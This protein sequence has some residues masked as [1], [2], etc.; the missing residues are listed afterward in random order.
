[1]NSNRNSILPEI[2]YKQPF[3]RK[4][5]CNKSMG[6][7]PTMTNYTVDSKIPQP[8]DTGRF[9]RKIYRFKIPSEYSK[10]S[11][12]HQ[13]K[14]MESFKLFNKTKMISQLPT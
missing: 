8:A 2:K 7:L 3:F 14:S 10:R 4:C 1:M 11:L 12:S 9:K 13:N 5:N 6:V